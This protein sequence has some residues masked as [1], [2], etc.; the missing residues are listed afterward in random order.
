MNCP[1]YWLL[2]RDER[3]DV[4]GDD[5]P[6]KIGGRDTDVSMIGLSLS[7]LADELPATLTSK[8]KKTVS[9]MVK[10]CAAAEEAISEVIE[11]MACRYKE[12][13]R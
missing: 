2:S 1:T 9:R 4:L 5:G 13:K 3:W 8:D 12:T 7:A 11:V 6:D 10:L